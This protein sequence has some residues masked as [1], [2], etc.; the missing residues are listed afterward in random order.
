MMWLHFKVQ[1]HHKVPAT[2]PITQASCLHEQ[3]QRL[4]IWKLVYAEIRG[5]NPWFGPAHDNDDILR[6]YQTVNFTTKGKVS[7]VQIPQKSANHLS[8]HTAII[9][10]IAW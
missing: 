10:Y 3:L 4:I 5:S 7:I 8:L 6:T 2:D 9:K 1:R